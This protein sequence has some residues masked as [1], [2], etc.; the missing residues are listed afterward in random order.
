LRRV[1]TEYHRGKHEDV[2]VLIL[3]AV[4]AH[5]RFGAGFF[6]E[7]LPIPSFFNWNLRKQKALVC[8]VLHQQTVLTN[9]DLSNIQHAA[10]RRKH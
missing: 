5:A 1:L 10:K 7:P 3:P 9:F 4:G 2:R 6:Q 8:A